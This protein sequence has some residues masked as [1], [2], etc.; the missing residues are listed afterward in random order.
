MKKGLTKPLLY[1]IRYLKFIYQDIYLIYLQLF[2]SNFIFNVFE[3][4]NMK[5]RYIKYILYY[6][7]CK[8][9]VKTLSILISIMKN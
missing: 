5:R 9:H 3:N 4:V 6:K 7:Y 2:L 8:L 1:E